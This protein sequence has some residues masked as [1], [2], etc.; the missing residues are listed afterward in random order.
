MTTRARCRACDDVPDRRSVFTPEMELSTFCLFV[1]IRQSSKTLLFYS[2]NV[3]EERWL[4]LKVY[5]SIS[6]LSFEVN[7]KLLIKWFCFWS[8][9]AGSELKKKTLFSA[10]ALAC[11][12]PLH[13]VCNLVGP[14]ALIVPTYAENKTLSPEV[15]CGRASGNILKITQK[16]IGKE[17]Q[18]YGKLTNK[19]RLMALSLW[20]VEK[21]SWGS[22]KQYFL[23]SVFLTVAPLF[24]WCGFTHYV[25]QCNIHT[26]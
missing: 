22:C 4:S 5:N 20:I 10:P 11:L 3:F 2:Q 1:H 17:L 8:S 19:T 23:R 25:I 9:Y 7:Q 18:M 24:W 12:H 14:S 15:R 13:Y 16:T 21:W 6:Q 26:T